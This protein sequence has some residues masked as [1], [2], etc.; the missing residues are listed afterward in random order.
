MRD[1]RGVNWLA[2]HEAYDDPSSSPARR[3]EWFGAGSEQSWTQRHANGG[4]C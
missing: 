2:W 3:L 1:A 4:N